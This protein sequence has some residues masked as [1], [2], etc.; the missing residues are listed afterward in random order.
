MAFFCLVIVAVAEGAPD[1]IFDPIIPPSA[2]EDVAKWATTALEEE[3]EDILFETDNY[4]KLFSIKSAAEQRSRP[5]NYKLDLLI[6]DTCCPK[7]GSRDCEVD[8]LIY[9]H[10][11]QLE[12]HTQG[13]F[14]PAGLGDEILCWP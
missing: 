13:D 9:V 7:T 2:A 4:L 5:D 8:C 1:P 10:D 11:C 6:D 12:Y 3:M 14:G